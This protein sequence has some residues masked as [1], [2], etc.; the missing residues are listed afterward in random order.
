MQIVDTTGRVT[1]TTKPEHRTYAL[2][3]QL[4][5]EVP[6]PV[7]PTSSDQVIGID[8][9]VKIAVAVSDGRAFHMPDETTIDNQI[10]TL[11]QSR[12]R[13]TY[14]SHQW[15]RRSDQL[16]GLYERRSHLRDETDRH[17]A[18]TIATTRQHLCGGC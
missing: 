7:K 6:D 9:G 2:H 14:G 13:C 12:A 3:A 1:R 18:K 16:R 4:V 10:K 8:A 17:I 11:Q 5:L 15:N